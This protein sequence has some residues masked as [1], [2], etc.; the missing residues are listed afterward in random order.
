MEYFKLQ[1][2]KLYRDRVFK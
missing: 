1:T 2:P